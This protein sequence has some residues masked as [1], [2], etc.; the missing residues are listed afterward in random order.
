MPYKCAVG[1]CPHKSWIHKTLTFY[2]FPSDKKLKRKWI[3]AINLRTKSYKWTASDRVCSAHFRDGHKYGCNDIPSIF[4]RLDLKTDQI[5][6]P[7][8]ISCLLLKKA[9]E[10]KKLQQSNI[11]I[12]VVQSSE[13]MMAVSPIETKS[14]KT[15]APESLQ[16]QM[17]AMEVEERQC[18]CQKEIDG[19]LERIRQLEE[20]REMERFGVRRFMASDSDMRFYTG[21][22]DYQTFLSL[23]NFLKPRPGFSLNY[24]NGYSKRSKDPSYVVLRGRPR[25][26]CAIDELFL[27]MTRLR[28]GLLEKD[29]A[30]RFC[31][32]QQ[33]VSEIF[34]TWIDRMSDFLGQLCFVTD[35]ETMRKNL[36]R[37]FRPN[38]EDVYLIIDCTE[39][40]IEKPSQVIQ[41]SATWSEYKGHNTGK[42]L[43]GL[44]PLMLPVFVSDIYPG[45]KSD[46][47]ILSDSGILS[48]AHQGD[49]WLA[50]KGFLVQH[51]LDNFGVRVETPAKLE[52]KQQFSIEEDVHNRKNSQVRVHVER[53]IRRVKV[54]K[55]LQGN[56]PLRYAHQIS[57]LWKVCCWLT[58]FLPPL[59]RDDGELVD[60]DV[61]E[62]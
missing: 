23:Y 48:H 34:S 53:G 41:Q 21:L 19:L 10:E 61:K 12:P 7:V 3:S 18:G 27:T 49:R 37:C 1:G 2:S 33:E 51:V 62:E 54:F 20:R 50:D 57:K 32:S 47:E 38:Y 22:P 13:S 16:V 40:F 17:P 44:S 4:P 6:W 25:L 14:D 5:V 55:I 15:P 8:D 36:P 59:I 45:S 24:Y 42:G 52:G 46:E 58:A 35:R 28:L 30:D 29:L 9:P 31:I 60:V 56:I 39:L 26:L 43:I 11:N